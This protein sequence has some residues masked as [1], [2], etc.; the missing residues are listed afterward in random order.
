[1]VLN[2]TMPTV[3]VDV[4]LNKYIVAVNDTY[5][6][7]DICIKDS[8]YLTI[9]TSQDLT[10]SEQANL[11]AYI[12]AFTNTDSEL[13]DC[14]TLTKTSEWGS[15]MVRQFS[16]NNMN[17]KRLGTMGRIELKNIMT[18]IHDSLV[19]MCLIAGSLDTLHG[20]LYGFPDEGSGGEA[21]LTFTHVWEEDITWMKTE[22]TTFLATL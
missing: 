16:I 3:I 15:M 2:Y 6:I 13:L 18:E 12:D 20:L 14:E 11:Q 4:Y 10:S 19:Y 21:A 22:L 1:M 9:T 5:Y 8:R 7:T 17:R